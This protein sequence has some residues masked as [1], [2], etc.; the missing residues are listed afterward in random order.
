MTI[1][2]YRLLIGFCIIMSVASCGPKPDATD[3]ALPDTAK[4]D[5]LI[6]NGRKLQNHRIDS[7]PIIAEKLRIIGGHGNKK[8]LLYSEFFSSQYYWLSSN[9][10]KSMEIAIKCLSDAEKW[11]ITEI[12][13]DIYSTIA[14][15]HKES[16]NYKMA[17]DAG[18]KAL[19]WAKLNKD[20]S[21][22]IATLSLKAMF[23]L[24]SGYLT[25]TNRNPTAR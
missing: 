17:F 21:A 4:T 7:L 13:P 12:Y 25:T 11:N 10:D 18:D 14:N 20:T 8:A 9:H 1:T 2:L 23:T 6:V 24:V 19:A 22:I 3:T 16:S 5:S 15:L